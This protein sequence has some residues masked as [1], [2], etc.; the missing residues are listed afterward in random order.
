MK[1]G[2]LT[3]RP[4]DSGFGWLF[5]SRDVV[6]ALVVTGIDEPVG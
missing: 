5:W 1:A 4:A 3:L 6:F 2:D